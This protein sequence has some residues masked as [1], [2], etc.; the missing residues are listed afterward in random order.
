VQSEQGEDLSHIAGVQARLAEFQ[1]RGAQRLIE[2]RRDVE[3]QLAEVQK[4]LSVLAERL[5]AQ[6]QTYERMTIQ[7]PVSGTVVDL[8]FH[9]VGGAIPSGERIMYIVPDGDEL[10][11]E[12]RLAPQY[13][14]RVRPGLE[15][16]V[17]FDAYMN[18]VNTPVVHGK[19]DV[20][21]ADILT[22]RRTGTPYYS[23]RVSIPGTELAKL[24][25]VKLQPGMQGTVM[26]KTGERSL[27]VYL[28]RP[29]LRRFNSALTEY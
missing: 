24:G 18:R 15:A 4:E 17:H 26:A 10:I 7:A 14:D 21:S 23:M 20:V 19:V 16:A 2:Y 1:M 22:D 6:R 12:A 3:T 28:L 5:V 8:A 29:L 25:E 11:M 27:L 13:V 9:T